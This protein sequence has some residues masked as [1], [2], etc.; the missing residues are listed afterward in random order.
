MKS[1][2]FVPAAEEEMTAAA[3]YYEGQR[4][5]LGRRF[6]AAVRESLDKIRIAPDLYPVLDLCGQKPHPARFLTNPAPDVAEQHERGD[7]TTDEC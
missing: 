1:I 4:H 5:R 3:A 7:R 6:L 2:R